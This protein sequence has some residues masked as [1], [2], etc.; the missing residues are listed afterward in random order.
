MDLNSSILTDSIND[1]VPI[2][3]N[4]NSSVSSQI[5]SAVDLD[6]QQQKQTSKNNVVASSFITPIESLNQIS[7]VL[8][9]DGHSLNTA[10]SL[11]VIKPNHQIS[12]APSKSVASNLINQ[13]QQNV[14]KSL[15]A[16]SFITPIESLNQISSVLISDGHSLR[17]PISLPF[18]KPNFQIYNISPTP[19]VSNSINQ[20][21]QLANL[22][23]PLFRKKISNL[24]ITSPVKQ[25][26]VNL[27]SSPSGF[28]SLPIN[29][30]NLSPNFNST[31]ISNS[32]PPPPPLINSSLSSISH[33]SANN[34]PLQPQPHY[35]LP[36][37][38][39]L[40]PRRVGIY[41]SKG[42]CNENV[43]FYSKTNHYFYITNGVHRKI[44]TD[45]VYD[46]NNILIKM[47]DFLATYYFLQD[48]D[49]IERLKLKLFSFIFYFIILLNLKL[50]KLE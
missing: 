1:F 22:D 42:C 38:N 43:V 39:S 25:K 40:N 48:H 30:N 7:S 10:N 24:T 21:Q 12:N 46:E 26:L 5:D 32:L 27:M 4:I 23:I 35:I 18:S 19:R 34:R 28:S 20:K 9:S 49:N 47:S 45:C 36:N 29:N 17:T 31:L 6:I 33:Q 50:D 11:P 37:E 3:S 14:N 2:T 13:K 41:K 44:K 8:I 15:A 16:S